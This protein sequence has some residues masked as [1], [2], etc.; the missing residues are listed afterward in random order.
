MSQTA[1]TLLAAVERAAERAGM[2]GDRFRTRALADVQADVRR[3]A[4]NS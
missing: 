3:L 1:R 2:P 4:K